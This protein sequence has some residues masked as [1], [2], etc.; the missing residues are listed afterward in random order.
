MK[1][2][3]P[4]DSLRKNS[5]DRC[6]VCYERTISSDFRAFSAFYLETLSALVRAERNEVKNRKKILLH[7]QH[8]QRVLHH[9]ESLPNTKLFN[10]RQT[11]LLKSEICKGLT[12]E[13][14]TNM[15]LSKFH[16]FQI[17]VDKRNYQITVVNS[18]FFSQNE[19]IIKQKL[20]SCLNVFYLAL[21]L[22]NCPKQR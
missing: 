19:D 2:H 16:D 8:L 20:F 6:I 18:R 9:T 1:W 11:K 21:F 7:F 4:L 22:E 3:V 12:V 10:F 14:F 15:P 13:I 17:F 5:Q